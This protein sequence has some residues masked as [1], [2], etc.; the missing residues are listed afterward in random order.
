MKAARKSGS[1]DTALKRRQP[2]VDLPGVCRVCGCSELDPCVIPVL[3]GAARLRRRGLQ[4]CSWFDAQ[5]TLCTNPQ[6]IALSPGFGEDNLGTEIYY[7]NVS[8][9]PNKRK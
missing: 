5:R 6:C 3:E 1:S 8:I 7:D 2:I 4:T 9:T